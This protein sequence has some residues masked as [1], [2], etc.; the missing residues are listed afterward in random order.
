MFLATFLEIINT[1]VIQCKILKVIRY[2]LLSYILT[3]TTKIGNMPTLLEKAGLDE[4]KL[5]KKKSRTL[6][7]DITAKKRSLTLFYASGLSPSRCTARGT[8][9]LLPPTL[10]PTLQ[11]FSWQLDG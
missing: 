4:T 8:C 10:D 11:F 1:R 5:P 2:F 3:Y 7:H 6:E 9:P